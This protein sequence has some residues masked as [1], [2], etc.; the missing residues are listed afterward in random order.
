MYLPFFGIKILSFMK[1]ILHSPAFREVSTCLR[2]TPQFTFTSYIPKNQHPRLL[3][4][5][6]YTCVFPNQVHHCIFHIF[7][8]LLCYTLTSPRHVPTYPCLYLFLSS[9]KIWLLLDAFSLMSVVSCSFPV[10]CCPPWRA[11]QLFSL[12]VKGLREFLCKM[13]HNMQ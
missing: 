6:L 7:F 9:W 3:T 4:P 8:T 10:L 5:S 1:G 11:A 2:P 12:P 13:L